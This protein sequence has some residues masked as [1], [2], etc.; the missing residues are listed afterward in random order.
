MRTFLI[1]LLVILL[2]VVF[3]NDVGRYS[4][5]R[6]ALRQATS[7][8]VDTLSDYAG[9]K[10]RNTAAVRAAELAG[11]QSNSSK[12][13]IEVY[14]YDQNGQGIQVWTRAYV[15]GTWVIGP[16]TAWRAGKP[17]GTPFVVQDYGTSVYR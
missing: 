6:I 3:I 4:R 13:Q 17:L 12:Q 5:A 14:Q 15:S 10:T 8:I 11:Q 2:A 16:F 9:G 1:V 7:S